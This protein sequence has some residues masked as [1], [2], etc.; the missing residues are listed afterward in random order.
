LMT[1]ELVYKLVRCKYRVCIVPR[2]TFFFASNVSLF[3]WGNLKERG[4]FGDPDVDGR[5]R[6][7]WIFRKW[8]V[9]L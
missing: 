4:H 8:D 7:R 1:Y 5:I 6:V 3:W 2:H 9:G